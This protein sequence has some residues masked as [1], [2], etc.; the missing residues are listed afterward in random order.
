MRRRRLLVALLAACDTTVATVAVAQDLRRAIFDGDLAAVR[1]ALRQKAPVNAAEP[2]G[3]TP[4]M[5]AAT[6]GTGP[7]VEI[8]RALLDAGA[9]LEAVN[10]QATRP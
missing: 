5:N 8:V 1:A 2:R 10:D 4:L 3:W 9:S 7:R 6:Y